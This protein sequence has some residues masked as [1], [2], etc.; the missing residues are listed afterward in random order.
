MLRALKY[1]VVFVLLTVAT[2]VGGIILLL[3]ALL[4][5]Q[6]SKKTK[7]I[8]FRGAKAVTFLVVYFI[9]TFVIIPPIAKLNG[10]VPLP[11]SSSEGVLQPQNSLT[12]LLNRHYVTPKLHETLLH[13]CNTF[14]QQYPTSTILY[15]D[16]NFPFIKG[17]PLVPHLS[18]NDGKKVDLAFLYYDTL[19]NKPSNNTP[20]YLGYGAYS[21][22]KPNERNTT[23][24]CEQKGYWQYSLLGKI[25]PQ[26]SNSHLILDEERTKT[27]LLLLAQEQNINKI[28]IEP[29]LK[30]RL[31]LQRI[32]K[33][34]FHGCQAVRHDDHIHLQQ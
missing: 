20:S 8:H 7:H 27:L 18:H 30:T 17:F 22:P 19:Q 16:A 34:R 9:F 32:D 29:H 31:N 11:I 2:Q 33:V 1:I 23:I 26:K 15:L 3:S 14:K 5:K 10:R 25:L 6:L 28:F 24:E 4:Y 13:S 21:K 12:Y